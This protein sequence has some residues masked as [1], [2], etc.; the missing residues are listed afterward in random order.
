MPIKLQKK[1]DLWTAEVTPPHGQWKTPCSMPIGHLVD[2]LKSIG[3]RQEDIDLALRETYLIKR[4]QDWN[5][6]MMPTL[7]QAIAGILDVSPQNP[8][9]EGF[10]AYVLFDRESPLALWE[11]SD[12]YD[13]WNSVG[14]TSD[15][16][17]W[18]FVRMNARGWLAEHGTRFGL[19]AEGRKSVA[20]IVG[21]GRIGD[22][23][24]RLVEWTQA[25]PPDDDVRA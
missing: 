4:E 21:E 12:A 14:M 11:I 1:N 20:E 6:E 5:S 18:A 23:I 3:C 2:Q 13:Y 17:A 22:K 24:S 16:L 19:T 7:R 15:A 25:N 10:I 8:S 9:D